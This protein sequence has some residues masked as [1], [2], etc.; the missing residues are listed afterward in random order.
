VIMRF[1]GFIVAALAIL[2]IASCR[3]QEANGR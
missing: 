3:A 2:A 1:S